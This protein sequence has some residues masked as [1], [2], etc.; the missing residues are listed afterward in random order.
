MYKLEMLTPTR[1]VLRLLAGRL[2]VDSAKQNDW[3]KRGRKPIEDMFSGGP[4]EV[5]EAYFPSTDATPEVVRTAAYR[6]EAR[7]SLLR[8]ADELAIL[9]LVIWGLGAVVTVL[10][11]G[12]WWGITV[13]AAGAA[14]TAWVRHRGA[15][16][17]SKAVPWRQGLEPLAWALYIPV[18]MAQQVLAV[19][20]E[21]K[22]AGDATIAS[23]WKALEAEVKRGPDGAAL[24]GQDAKILAMTMLLTVHIPKLLLSM[25]TS[26]YLAETLSRRAPAAA[27]L[28][29]GELRH[30]VGGRGD[31][32]ATRARGALAETLAAR[33][34]NYLMS[35]SVHFATLPRPRTEVPDMDVPLSTLAQDPS[36]QDLAK[37]S[38][39]LLAAAQDAAQGRWPAEAATQWERPKIYMWAL[40][41]RLIGGALTGIGLILSFRP[42]LQQ[43]GH[44]LIVIGAT[45]IPGTLGS[46]VKE[47]AALRAPPSAAST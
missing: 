3:L 37:R 20:E 29:R 33:A 2:T 44:T 13:A 45:L 46:L 25:D 19:M 42:A 21:L 1:D 47:A 38:G 17:A 30:Q 43:L 36:V 8:A 32:K 27:E 9:L 16:E 10:I 14:L 41:G 40:T 31:W 7:R 4:D 5:R 34:Y 18:Q 11:M 6:V 39:E 15:R 12:L 35:E 28:I 26:R 23:Q 24:P 22:E